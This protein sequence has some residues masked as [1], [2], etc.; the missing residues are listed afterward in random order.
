MVHIKPF[1]WILQFSRIYITVL[2][3]NRGLKKNW[4]GVWRRN[5]AWIECKVAAIRALS[6]WN[7]R[8]ISQLSERQSA[9][10]PT[11]E[12][13]NTS[14]NV[15]K[16][17]HCFISQII[18]KNVFMSPVGIGLE[19][20]SLFYW[21]SK[22][23]LCFASDRIF[24]FIFYWVNSKNLVASIACLWS[25]FGKLGWTSPPSGVGSVLHTCIQ[26]SVP[27]HREV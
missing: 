22:C 25:T 3:M 23:W 5:L 21:L 1:P 8:H 10:G 18:F 9:W 24:H 20:Y 14:T 15:A 13:Q 26:M 2:L 12:E 11:Y 7:C 19:N 6:R 17:N 16:G 27:L 4:E